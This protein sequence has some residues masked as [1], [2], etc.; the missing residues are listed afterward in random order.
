MGKAGI[1]QVIAVEG[2]G[3]VTWDG[4][5]RQQRAQGPDPGWAR[6]LKEGTFVR[7]PGDE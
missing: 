6:H 1:Q 2:L 5:L 7:D 3:A 4:V